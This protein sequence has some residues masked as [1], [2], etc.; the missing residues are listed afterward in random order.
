MIAD[1]TLAAVDGD[2]RLAAS[3]LGIARR[4]VYRSLAAREAA[5]SNRE[6]DPDR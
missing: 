2:K 5:D 4:T 1:A 6:D 3:M